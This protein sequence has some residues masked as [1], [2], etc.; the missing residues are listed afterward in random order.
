FMRDGGNGAPNGVPGGPGATGEGSVQAAGVQ[1]VE[2]R[3]FVSREHSRCDRDPARAGKF[4]KTEIT[5]VPERYRSL[6][7]AEVSIEEILNANLELRGVG[8]CH[9]PGP[10]RSIHLLLG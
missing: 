7:G 2:L 5:E 1:L 3:Q 9:V 4:I 10:G 8:E 6:M